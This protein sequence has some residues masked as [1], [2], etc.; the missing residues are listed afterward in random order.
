MHPSDFNVLFVA[1][2]TGIFKTTNGGASWA[3]V[4]LQG[5]INNNVYDIEFMPN[6]PQI[7][8]AGVDGG[9]F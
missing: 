7:M 6:N 3:N 1:T 8:Y 5:Y 2:N 9:K 4:L